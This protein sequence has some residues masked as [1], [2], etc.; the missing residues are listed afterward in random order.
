M[1]ILFD[2]TDP[3]GL[4]VRCE[5]KRWRQHIVAHHPGLENQLDLVKETIENP[6]MI[7]RDATNPNREVYYS[8][9]ILPAP[10]DRLYLKIIV[11]FSERAGKRYG[12]VI[13]AYISDTPKTGEKPIWISP[14]LSKF[15]L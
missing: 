5:K 13:T 3:R 8:L 11:Q 7:C 4:S 12:T 14:Q 1:S 9:G 15:Q 10:F 6:L 2:T